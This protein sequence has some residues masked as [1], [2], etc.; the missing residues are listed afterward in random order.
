SK[1]Y[2]AGEDGDVTTSPWSFNIWV[3]SEVGQ[4]MAGVVCHPAKMRV[5]SGIQWGRCLPVKAIVGFPEERQTTQGD[6]LSH[7][8]PR[9]SVLARSRFS[10][11]CTIS[12]IGSEAPDRVHQAKV[13]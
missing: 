7:L 9:S 6:G 3:K 5:P 2:H 13:P 10:K 11:K 12:R 4:T 1:G 8:F